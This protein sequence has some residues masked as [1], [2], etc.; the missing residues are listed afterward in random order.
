[1]RNPADLSLVRK[2]HA[3]TLAIYRA[4]ANLRPFDHVEVEELRGTV[5]ALETLMESAAAARTPSKR[6]KFIDMTLGKLSRLHC[7][8]GICRDVKTL[9]PAV[10]ARLTADVDAI[11]DQ[12][13]EGLSPRDRAAREKRWEWLVKLD[14]EIATSISSPSQPRPL[15]SGPRRKGARIRPS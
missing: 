12:V 4:T 2:C 7:E 5:V 10:V 11:Y 1:M 13:W 3:L 8:L 15:P 6:S 14:K 9:F